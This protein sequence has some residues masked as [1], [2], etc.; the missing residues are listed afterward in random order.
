MELINLFALQDKLLGDFKVDLDREIEAG[1]TLDEDEMYDF[2]SEWADG[3]YPYYSDSWDIAVACRFSAYCDFGHIWEDA[4][5]A[6]DDLKDV[7]DLMGVCTTLFVEHCIREQFAGYEVV[8]D[9][10]VA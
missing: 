9:E 7:D 8:A 10:E 3:K 1:R 5:S 4:L 6:L 2:I